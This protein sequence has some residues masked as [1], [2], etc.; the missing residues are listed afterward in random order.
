MGSAISSLWQHESRRCMERKS[1]FV[2]GMCRSCC[3]PIYRLQHIIR[4]NTLLNT[5][6]EYKEDRGLR[7]KHPVASPDQVGHQDAP[8]EQCLKQCLQRSSIKMSSGAF[9]QKLAAG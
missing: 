5:I 9:R 1:S 8:F 2:T 3:W 6:V 4:L 7:L